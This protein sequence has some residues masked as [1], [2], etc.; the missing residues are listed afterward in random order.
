M[1]VALGGLAIGAAV[2]ARHRAQ[3]AADLGALA[4]A[5]VLASGP[6][7]ACGRAATVAAAGGAALRSCAVTGLDVVVTVTVR[8]GGRFA[9]EARAGA[10]AGPVR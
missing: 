9:G 6:A 2:V 8:A 10:R 1:A 7:A 3:S 5:T 4:A